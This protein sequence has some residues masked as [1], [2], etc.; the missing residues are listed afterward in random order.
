MTNNKKYTPC[1]LAEPYADFDNHFEPLEDFNHIP[2]ERKA[3]FLEKKTIQYQGEDDVYMV[4]KYQ[5]KSEFTTPASVRTESHMNLILSEGVHFI[6]LFKEK[7]IN[8][9]KAWVFL[10]PKYVDELQK[11]PYKHRMDFVAYGDLYRLQNNDTFYLQKVEHF[12]GWRVL[13]KWDIEGKEGIR[14]EVP[15]IIIQ[16]TL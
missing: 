11:F 2:E 6:P 7:G 9:E 3:D 12:E 5:L 8:L 13:R 16:I 1:S 15:E 14:P 4:E 10:D